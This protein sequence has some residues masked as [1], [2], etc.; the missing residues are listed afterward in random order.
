MWE[1]SGEGLAATC[2]WG[3]AGGGASP[4]RTGASSGTVSPNLACNFIVSCVL[5]KTAQGRGTLFLA[6][7]RCDCF[8]GKLR[9][10]LR[11]NV[12]R[13][14]ICIC[15]KLRQGAAGQVDVERHYIVASAG[16]VHAGDRNIG[17]LQAAVGSAENDRVSQRSGPPPVIT[18]KKSRDPNVA[19]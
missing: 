11:L 8:R 1:G 12:Q 13:P 19:T 5:L 6:L 9:G 18:P 4:V 3:A 10:R 15:R 7:A 2:G 14:G 16:L 17:Q